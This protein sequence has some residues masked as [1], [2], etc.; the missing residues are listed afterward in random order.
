MSA[1]A[2][3]LFRLERDVLAWL[4]TSFGYGPAARAVL[5]PGGSLANFA[6]VV[7]ARHEHFGETGNFERAMAYT[8]TQAHHSVLKAVRLA[9]VPEANVRAIDV[10]DAFRMRLD[11]LARAVDDDRRSGLAPFLVIASAGTTNTGAVDPLPAAAELCKK[12]KLWLH[13][14]GAYGGA[15]V[16]C[17][18]GKRRLAGIERADSITFDPHKGLFLPYGTGCLLVKDGQKLRRAHHVGAEYLQDLSGASPA[19]EQVGGRTSPADTLSWSPAELGPELSRD[20]R[21]LRLWLPLMLHG[22]RAFRDALDEKLA[23][24]ERFVEG[25]DGLVAA[26]APLEV[27][28]RPQL[29]LV[30]FRLARR[31]GEPLAAWNG[32][33]AALNAAVNDKNRVHL[34]STL[35]PVE[36]GTAF[37][38]RVCVLSFRSHARH[39]DRCLEDIAAAIAELA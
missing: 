33:N 36:D 5:T 38:L 32:R 15:F 34:S 6:A 25:L 2:P 3:A 16:L 13:V 18:D 39:I 12:E 21:G 14:D 7:A 17:E 24:A 37:T 29:S 19:D 1:P 23:L 10:D 11:E 9:G 4:T 28:A 8:S 26:G 35:L 30:A 31:R 27:V 22:A 20:F